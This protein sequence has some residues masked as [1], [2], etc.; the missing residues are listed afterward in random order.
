MYDTFA[1]LDQRLLLGQHLLEEVLVDQ[2]L[3][4][5]VKLEAAVIQGQRGQMELE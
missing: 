2:R 1:L 4:R 5:Q 3:R